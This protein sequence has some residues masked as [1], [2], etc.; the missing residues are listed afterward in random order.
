M[1]KEP[2][3]TYAYYYRGL[4]YDEQKQTKLAI[5]D[6]LY[7]INH[8]KDFPI[9]NYMAAIDFDSLENYNDAFKYYKKFI[10]EYTTEDEYLKY[11]KDRS[12]ELEPF[13]K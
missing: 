1:K 12:K 11:A 7:I 9:A 13:V 4:I 6:Y 10:E 5:N 3:N 2:A 8:S